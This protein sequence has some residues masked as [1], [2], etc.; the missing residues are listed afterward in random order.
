MT[1]IDKTTGWLRLAKAVVEENLL[2]WTNAQKALIKIGP[3]PD[4]R[5]EEIDN[6]RAQIYALKGGLPMAEVDELT[7]ERIKPIAKKLKALCEIESIRNRSEIA[8]RQAEIFMKSDYYHDVFE[9]LCPEL[10]L[11]SW[12]VY[13]E[14][15]LLELQREA[16][17]PRRRKNENNQTI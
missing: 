16:N 2:S 17:R 9:G 12:K 8:I 1:Q 5:D 10:T 7:L 4:G 14:Q 3:K 11:C 6:L 13:K 15:K